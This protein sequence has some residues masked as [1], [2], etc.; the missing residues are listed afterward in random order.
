MKKLMVCFLL[1]ASLV[2]AAF[3]QQLD[4]TGVYVGGHLGYG[5][6]ESSGGISLT[7]P[8]AGA[9]E[10]NELTNGWP[11]DL[12]PRGSSFGFQGGYNFQ[13]SSNFVLGAEFDYSKLDMASSNNRRIVFAA[14]G[15]ATDIRNKLDL[16]NMLSLRAKAGYV[17]G[18]TLFYVTAGWAWSKIEA[19]SELFGE[20]SLSG[21][22]SKEGR[23][24]KTLDGYTVGLGLEHR[25]TQNLSIRGDYKYIDLGKVNY[26]TV[27]RPG[28]YNPYSWK[29][30]ISQD[31][32]VHLFNIGLNYHF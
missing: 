8:H 1:V 2:P 21:N 15:I 7:W 31:L 22:Y 25:F 30:S 27:N 11:K 13:A 6:G 32:Q 4:W 24:S 12:N 23:L 20:Y 10:K 16:D 17:Y 26:A 14:S 19:S 3:A 28:G 18:Q 5:V 29:E 9:A